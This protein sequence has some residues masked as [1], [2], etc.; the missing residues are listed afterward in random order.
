MP[1]WLEVAIEVVVLDF[2]QAV[3]EGVEFWQARRRDLANLVVGETD[4]RFADAQLL[5]GLDVALPL[6]LKRVVRRVRSL[7]GGLV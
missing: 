5:D 4:E 7:L 1:R 6:L 2:G 3:G